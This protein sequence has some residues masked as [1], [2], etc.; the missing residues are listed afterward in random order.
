MDD[1]ERE[2]MVGENDIGIFQV[3]REDIKFLLPQ[4]PPLL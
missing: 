2:K 3:A 4:L 1:T